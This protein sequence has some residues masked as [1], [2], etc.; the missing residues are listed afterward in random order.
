M[1]STGT[2]FDDYL[3]RLEAAAQSLPPGPR[4]ELLAQV[5]EHLDALRGELDD[6]DEAAVRQALDRLGD[7]DDIVREAMEA[8]GSPRFGSGSEAPGATEAP[9]ST[10]ARSRAPAFEMIAVI[11]LLVGGFALGVGWIVGLVMTWSSARWTI[12][13]KLLG[14]LVWPG[15]LMSVFLLDTLTVGYESCSGTV[16]TD[17][18]AMDESAS[19]P[20]D[21]MDCVTSGFVLPLWAGIPVGI[22]LV[23][24][25]FATAAYLIHRAARTRTTS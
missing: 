10:P 20:G 24:A 9:R 18:G 13:E 4:A 16:V 6:Q 11:L 23:L 7:P 17:S 15:G 25:P 14:T 3:R 8:D 2:A 19:A 21:Q 22:L 12:R 5:R 1:N